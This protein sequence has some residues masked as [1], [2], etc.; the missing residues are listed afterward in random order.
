MPE[1]RPYDDR[2]YVE[3][4]GFA[5]GEAAGSA[6]PLIW[7]QAQYLRLLRDLQNSRISDQ[8]AITRARYITN[9]PPTPLPVAISSPNS[10][11]STP[12]TVVSGITTP[13]ANVEIASSQ[14]GSADNSTKTVS[15]VADGGGA[16]SATVPT[17][18]GQSVITAAATSGDHTSGWD[19][20]TVTNP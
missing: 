18:A 14:P 10:S 7:G 13:G 4:I 17:P 1:R 2:P 11:T 19:Q 12:T 15:T 8:P 6:A 3:S 5:N 20:E 16:F 9:G